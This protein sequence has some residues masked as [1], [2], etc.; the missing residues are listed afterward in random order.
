MTKRQLIKWLESQQAR[1]LVN[2]EEQYKAARTAL[3]EKRDA[4]IKIEEVVEAL[5]SLISKADDVVTEWK[6]DLEN[7]EIA[8]PLNGYFGSMSHFLYGICDKDAIRNRL[9]YDF[10]DTYPELIELDKKDAEVKRAIRANYK[11]VIA[12]VQNMSNAKLAV[13][14]LQDLGFDLSSLTE[15]DRYS[16]SNALTV[17][18]D[19]RFLFI[20]SVENEQS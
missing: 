16:G 2:E 20:G 17:A 15:T 10:S 12:N 8:D 13:Q 18:V 19:T 7:S 1:V 3:I 11:S 6:R 9:R 5:Y 14:Y 4:A